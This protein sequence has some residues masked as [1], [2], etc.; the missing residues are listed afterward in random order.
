MPKARYIAPQFGG[1]ADE[2]ETAFYNALRASD[3]DR[4][5]ACWADED[6]VVCVY[7]GG[8]RLVGV[9]AI[10]GAFEPILAVGS[11]RIHPEHPRRIINTLGVAAHSMLERLE[12]VNPEGGGMQSVWVVATNVYL[13]TGAGWRMVAHHAS[14]SRAEVA[15]VTQPGHLLH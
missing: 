5:M 8:P 7:P 6:D 3:I 2:V 4:F 13:R 9:A 14:A 15:E 11:M 10:R 1:S 12:V